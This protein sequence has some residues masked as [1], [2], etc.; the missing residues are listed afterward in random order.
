VTRRLLPAVLLALVVCASAVSAQ[1]L[2]GAAPTS[3]AQPE[4][5]KDLLGRS[6]PRGAVLGFLA[7]VVRRAYLPG[8]GASP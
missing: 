7:A 1:G 4:A 8:T 5:P 6:T 2:P 3:P